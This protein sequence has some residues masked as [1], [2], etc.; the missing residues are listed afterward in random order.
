MTDTHTLPAHRPGALET[1][2]K[3]QRDYVLLD[4]SGSMSTKW[5]ESLAAVQAYLETVVS[6]NVESHFTLHV[7]DD[8]DM[9]YI[10]RDGIISSIDNVMNVGSHWGGTPLYDAINLMVR[11]LAKE[12]PARC[13]IVIVTDGEETSSEYTDE[14]QARAL[15]DWCRAKGWQVTFIGAEF[16]NSRQAKKLGATRET[17]IG[18]TRARL[19]DASKNLGKKRARYARGGDEMSFNEDERQQFGGYLAGPSPA[20]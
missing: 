6:E 1:I 10:A 9:E 5:N 14:T 13:S 11:K 17:A 8:I 15:L 12:D 4:G 7:F 3:Q 19:S 18:V 20:K 2:G 16:D